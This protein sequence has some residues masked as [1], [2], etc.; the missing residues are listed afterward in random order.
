MPEHRMDTSDAALVQACRAG[1][2][3]AWETL[4]NRY[5]RFVHDIPRRA[6][7]DEDAAAD[8]FQE[9]FVAL[10]R[11]LDKVEQPER[12]SAWLLTITK[13]AT[14]RHVRRRIATRE[15]VAVL[16][17]TAEDAPDGALLPEE[18]FLRLEEQHAVRTAV[19]QLDDRCRRLLT[20]LFYTAQP[21]S[22]SDVAAALNIS[23]GSIGPIRARCLQRVL[24]LLKRLPS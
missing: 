8:V 2:E 23:E 13:R 9:V 1:D 3:G 17:E 20:M 24:R 10:I 5:Q 12:L 16:D 21:P 15:N 14:W 19:A 18:S 6:G 7:L 22:Y 4:V 11:S